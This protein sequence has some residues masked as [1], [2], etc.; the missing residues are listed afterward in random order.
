M[1]EAYLVDATGSVRDGS[2]VVA[3][4]DEAAIVRSATISEDGVRGGSTIDEAVIVGF[5]TTPVGVRE[6]NLEIRNDEETGSI[7][8]LIFVSASTS[9]ALLEVREAAGRDDVPVTVPGISSV[10][11]R[12]SCGTNLEERDD[13]PIIETGISFVVTSFDE[14]HEAAVRNGGPAR[15]RTASISVDIRSS[16]TAGRISLSR[17]DVCCIPVTSIGDDDGFAAAA[18]GASTHL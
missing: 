15:E 13:V 6:A 2:F 4:D 10:R 9:K 5:A 12:T 17:E 3:Y 8:V 18:A 11:G 7:S 14:V 16:A 1:R